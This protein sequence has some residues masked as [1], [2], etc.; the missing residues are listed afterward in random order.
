VADVTNA[1]TQGLT[2]AWLSGNC[3]V[4][5]EGTFDGRAFYFRA[6]GASVTCD[7][8]EWTWDGPEYEWPDAGWISEDVARA[9][10]AAAYAEWQRRGEKRAL[11][12]AQYRRRNGLHG[13]AMQHL[14]FFG[15]ID[16]ALG[17]AGKPASDWLMAEAQRLFAS[18]DEEAS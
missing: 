14:R 4:Q 7:V 15:A 13:E 11:Q 1:E 2:I 5:A 6:R 16:A 9:Y 12:R 3:P 10:I 17:D 8:G 18:A